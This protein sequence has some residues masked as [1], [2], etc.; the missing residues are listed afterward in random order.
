ME[1][2]SNDK[3]LE[4][5]KER[6]SIFLSIKNGY[7]NINVIDTL[8]S[9]VIEKS[10][11]LSLMP[12]AE[13]NKFTVN[14]LNMINAKLSHHI[15]T[16]TVLS[17]SNIDFLNDS[18]KDISFIKKIISIKNE[19]KET[20]PKKLSDY[21]N[22]VSQFKNHVGSFDEVFKISSEAWKCYKSSEKEWNNFLKQN[23]Y[24]N[25]NINIGFPPGGA[26]SRNDAPLI[27]NEKKNKLTF[28]YRFVKAIMT[29]ISEEEWINA[30]THFVKSEECWNSYL[31]GKVIIMDD[32]LDECKILRAQLVHETPKKYTGSNKDMIIK[33]NTEFDKLY[34]INSVLKGCQLDY[35]IIRSTVF[36]WCI[37]EEDFQ[38]F[39][40]VNSLDSFGTFFPDFH[41]NYFYMNRRDTRSPNHV[42]VLQ[43][44]PRNSIYKF[45]K[46]VTKENY[47]KMMNE[48][49]WEEID[50]VAIV[51]TIENSGK[52]NGA[53]W[54]HIYDMHNY[55]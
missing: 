43:Q 35:E 12:L 1:S 40:K 33:F 4:S 38:E 27:S 36:N 26:P 42:P 31:Q 5:L 51:S 18:S 10:L 34:D 6:P 17:F 22:F 23:N 30:Y 39:L 25:V 14:F 21:N 2:L 52:K 19:I 53:F 24:E 41:K 55:F 50:H 3:F 46:E 8:R 49:D 47:F 9:L 29:T 28:F 20:A 16:L 48:I 13:R 45:Q 37:N 54:A 32:L 44:I 15:E 7:V 11:D